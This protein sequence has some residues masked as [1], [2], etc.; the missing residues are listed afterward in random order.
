MIQIWPKKSYT[1]CNGDDDPCPID[2]RF[3]S[4]L[5]YVRGSVRAVRNIH[6]VHLLGVVCTE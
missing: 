1:R 5:H 4:Q 3:R 6:L 2:D